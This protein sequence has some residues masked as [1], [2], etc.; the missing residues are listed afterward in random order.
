MSSL[1]L[2]LLAW[3]VA[4]LAFPC[5]RDPAP[6]FLVFLLI[7]WIGGRWVKDDRSKGD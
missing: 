4:H 5:G 2:A 1:S 6:P 3:L 7:L